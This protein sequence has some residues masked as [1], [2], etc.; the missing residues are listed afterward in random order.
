ML[1]AGIDEKRTLGQELLEVMSRRL[2]EAK[3]DDLAQMAWLAL[4]LRNY[5]Q[6]SEFVRRGLEL[7]NDNPYLLKLAEEP[8][9]SI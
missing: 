9:I 4:R 8:N 3:P 2:G 1:E 7:E 5:D 6:A